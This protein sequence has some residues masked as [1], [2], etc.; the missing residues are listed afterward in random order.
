MKRQ[1][2]SLLIFSILAFSNAVADVIR[3]DANK[4]RTRWLDLYIAK[5]PTMA[6]LLEL[7]KQGASSQV[8]DGK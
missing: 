4:E 1:L 7:I 2:T 8:S 3:I 5:E 6:S